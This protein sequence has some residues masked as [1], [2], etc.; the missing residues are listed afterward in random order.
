MREKR[1]AERYHRVW[2]NRRRRDN[3]RRS[4]SHDTIGRNLAGLESL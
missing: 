2:N 4:P 1:R 3:R